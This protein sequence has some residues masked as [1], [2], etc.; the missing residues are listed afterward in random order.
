MILAVFIWLIYLLV[1][2]RGIKKFIYRYAAREYEDDNYT[3]DC[4]KYEITIYHMKRCILWGRKPKIKF[5]I[6]NKTDKI[7]ED[8]EGYIDL[9]FG[10][11]CI[12]HKKIKIDYILPNL[13]R[14][15]ILLDNEL[16]YRN[17]ETAKFVLVENKGKMEAFSGGIRFL[18]PDIE[19]LL[20]KNKTCH[21][22]KEKFRKP[23]SMINW[24]WS[25]YNCRNT[26]VD[27]YVRS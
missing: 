7:I 8:L 15:E 13:A 5:K 16:A 19:Y 18:I 20:I 22:A 17:W 10:D 23:V 21:V 24:L 4:F 12:I 2:K 27:V 25:Y 3:I 9:F 1:A 6:R 14:E 26:F 11:T